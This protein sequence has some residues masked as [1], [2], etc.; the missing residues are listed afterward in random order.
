MGSV[1]KTAYEMF[2]DGDEPPPRYVVKET[3]FGSIDSSPPLLPISIIDVGLLS[4][5]SSPSSIEELE[6]LRS[7]LSTCGC[8][9]ISTHT[10]AFSTG[11]NPGEP[12]NPRLRLNHPKRR[13][14]T[15]TA[16]VLRRW[17][18][19]RSTAEPQSNVG[20]ETREARR[21]QGR[22]QRRTRE[23]MASPKVAEGRGTEAQGREVQGRQTLGF[24]HG[25]TPVQR[26]RRNTQGRGRRRTREG[27]EVQGRQTLG[28]TP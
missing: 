28:F 12:S 8:F 10:S 13:K 4:S 17:R 6:K 9:Q 21:T 14:R 19:Q 23:S 15:E 24:A 18:N 20:G 26:R 1:N 2:I 11:S 27:R 5:S 22:G 7:A 25:G 3:T 16:P